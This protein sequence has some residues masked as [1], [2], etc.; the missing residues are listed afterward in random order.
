MKRILALLLLLPALSFGQLLE[1]SVKGGVVTNNIRPVTLMGHGK[2]ENPLGY[3]ASLSATAGLPLNIR[4]GL[5]VSAYRVSYTASDVIIK[6][7]RYDANV[8]YGTPVIPIEAIVVKRLAISKVS[9]D[10]GFT[11]GFCLGKK[12][13]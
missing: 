7:N 8:D 13:C 4:A 1:V 10:L 11:G 5:S 2:G 12:N 6:Y 9:F 3:A